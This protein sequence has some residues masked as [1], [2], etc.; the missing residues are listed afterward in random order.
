MAKKGLL[1]VDRVVANELN[2]YVDFE[3]NVWHIPSK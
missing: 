2:G 3:N 1:I